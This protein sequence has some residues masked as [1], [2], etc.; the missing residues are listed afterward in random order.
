MSET[1]KQMRIVDLRAGSLTYDSAKKATAV[2]EAPG[3]DPHAAASAKSK[4]R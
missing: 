4:Y 3:D 1:E 2:L